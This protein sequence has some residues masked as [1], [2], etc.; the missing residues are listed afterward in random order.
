MSTKTLAAALL[1]DRQRDTGTRHNIVACRVCGSTYV[2]KGR[3]GDLNG[4]F[5]SLHC[6]DWHD[7]GNAPID[8]DH[9]AK[10]IKA[11]LE[12]WR[13]VAGLSGVEVG[14]PYYAGVS[15]PG[16]IFTKMTATAAGYR[17]KCAH[18][19]REFES[20]GLRCCSTECER[21]FCERKANLALMA[22]FGAEPSAKRHCVECGAIIPKW[23][24]GR[25]VSTAVR[26]CSGRCS[27]RSRRKAA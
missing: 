15:P 5:C 3:R 27:T 23:R 8:H 2:Y 19:A 18:C 14:A 25:R 11:P 10:A 6:Q 4:N 7:D 26:F 20:R 22:E 17:I 12:A 9:L 13:I 16:Y 1:A 24:N 21:A